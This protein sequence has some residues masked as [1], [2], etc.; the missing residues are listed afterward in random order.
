VGV[1]FIE[2]KAC[3]CKQLTH[4]GRYGWIYAGIGGSIF[5]KEFFPKFFPKFTTLDDI[6]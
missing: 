4:I 6:D 5:P 2:K 1:S 3:G